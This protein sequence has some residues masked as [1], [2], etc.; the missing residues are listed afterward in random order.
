MGFQVK[1]TKTIH[2]LGNGESYFSEKKD[3]IKLDPETVQANRERAETTGLVEMARL[4]ALRALDS[5]IY[6]GLVRG[7]VGDSEVVDTVVDSSLLKYF[8]KNPFRR[9]ENPFLSIIGPLHPNRNKPYSRTKPS[10]EDSKFKPLLNRDI[11]PPIYLDSGPSLKK[12]GLFRG[13]DG[14]DYP[15]FEALRRADRTWGM[16][17]FG[18]KPGFVDIDD[19]FKHPSKPK[20]PIEKS[21][22]QY[23]GRDGRDYPTLEA[24]M[25]ANRVW[26]EMDRLKARSFLN[27]NLKLFNEYERLNETI[28]EPLPEKDLSFHERMRRKRETK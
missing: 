19:P 5:F 27:E 4:E 6:K 25:R 28:I 15:T 22:H 26:T 21:F 7:I 12:L 20:P 8:S 23:I 13:R 24:I 2:F 1:R 3:R 16:E 11:I 14:R 18:T 9:D 10:P 17:T